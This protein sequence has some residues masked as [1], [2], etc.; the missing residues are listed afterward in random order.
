MICRVCKSDRL[1]SVSG[2]VSDMCSVDFGG[3]EHDGY[4]PDGLGIGGGDYIEFVLCLECG[5]VQGKFPKKDPDL[6]EE[7]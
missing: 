6:W 1:L 5:A 3:R 4:V 7:E 2:K